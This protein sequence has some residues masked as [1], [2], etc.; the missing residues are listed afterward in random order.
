MTFACVAIEN[1]EH[2]WIPL[3]DG[4][5]LAARR[6]QPVDALQTPVPA[7]L[8]YIPYRKR[9]GTRSRDE[10][11]D[12]FAHQGY[13]S[14]RVDM[15][16]SGESD[17]LLLDE[18]LIKEQDDA[19]ELIAWISEQPWCNGSVAMIGKS[20]G[21]F[22]ALQV[23]ARR[24]PALKTIVSVCSTD[25]RYTDDIHYCGGTLLND[26][27]WWG[28]IMLVYQ[29][30]P[31]DESIAGPEWR[32]KWTERLDAMPFWPAMWLENQRLNRYWMQ[33]SIGYDWQAIECPVF[34]W[35]GWSDSYSNALMRMLIN[36]KV[37]RLAVVGPWGHLYPH[38]GMPGP[39]IGFLQEVCR[40]WDFWLKDINTGI[41]KEPVLR[42][43]IEEWSNPWQQ[44]EHT[45]GHWVGEASWPSS[46]I[47]N[48][49]LF[50]ST[51]HQLCEKEPI[52]HGSY[53]ISSV[54]LTGSTAGAFMG[55]GWADHPS[56][57]RQDDAYS[58]VFDTEP[59]DHAIELLGS[60]IAHLQV[61]SDRPNGHICI[62]LCDI[63]PEG[64]SRR[65]SF[66]M[67]NLTHKDG[68]EK[69]EPLIPQKIYAI[70]MSLNDCGYRFDKGHRIR[71][72]ISPC[73]WPCVWPS[74]QQTTLTIHTPE[75][76]LSLPIRIPQ[77]QDAVIHFD[78]PVHG[79]KPAMTL[80][81]DNQTQRSYN[82]DYVAGTATYKTK[83]KEGLLAFDDI[84]TAKSHSLERTY[85]IN[86]LDPLTAYGQITQKYC[87][88][89]PPALF[90]IFSTVTMQATE[91][92]FIMQGSLD[93]FENNEPCYKKE[94]NATIARDYT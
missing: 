50:L 87:I 82:F 10:M 23:A 33:G 57:Q 83:T 30:R 46:T 12:Y 60:P 79:T 38:D 35:G 91:T 42:A 84:N 73:Y 51:A 59:L 88:K 93:I 70:S 31:L 71:M 48:Q 49:L 45:P 8:E 68:H 25:N 14:I 74:A 43:Y 63:A 27:L 32:K 94:F 2:F 62:R 9:D 13:V 64:S 29:A 56:D 77:E 66:Q 67:L 90:D 40:W 81:E 36:L 17:G 80:I 24:P 22:N 5:H 4:T 53:S 72:A 61:S 92:D 7:I 19:C 54:Q 37:P 78:L 6:W 34:L 44:R 15:R 21:G 75:S 89:Y 1:I 11:H 65:V 69:P 28:A 20:W 86:P 26:N 18:Y 16:G 39:A 3:S 55:S 76:Y 52:K 85:T 41:M 58:L 47:Q